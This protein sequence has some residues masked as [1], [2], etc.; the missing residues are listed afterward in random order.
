MLDNDHSAEQIP[1]THPLWRTL[2]YPS[3]VDLEEISEKCHLQSLIFLLGG[4][5]PLGLPPLR[6]T[7]A[8][9]DNNV[10]FSK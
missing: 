8:A 1:A 3:E 9:G 7:D 10:V 2:S 5:S 6:L 4:E